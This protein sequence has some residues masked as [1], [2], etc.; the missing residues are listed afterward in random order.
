[1][2][3]GNVFC[4]SL[5]LEKN[6]EPYVHEKFAEKK[7]KKKKGSLRFL[8]YVDC[9]WPSVSLGCLKLNSVII[10]EE[11]ALLNPALM[12]KVLLAI[13]TCNESKTFLLVVKLDCTS[14]GKLLLLFLLRL[15]DTIPATI[16]VMLLCLAFLQYHPLPTETALLDNLVLNHGSP[17]APPSHGIV[18]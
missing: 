7:E 18:P 13:F 1:V 3:C 14:H 15:L 5:L 8:C 11:N 2:S 9:L 4:Y 16:A 12:D 6:N 17:S 10:P